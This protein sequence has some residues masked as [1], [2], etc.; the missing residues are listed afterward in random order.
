MFNKQKN[1]GQMINNKKEVNTTK[2]VL[3]EQVDNMFDGIDGNIADVFKI[4]ID[5]AINHTA[6][7]INYDIINKG[8]FV[9][10]GGK[11]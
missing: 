4:A 11:K 8:A 3:L 10:F 9:G 6:H 5:N 7:E 2:K 1:G